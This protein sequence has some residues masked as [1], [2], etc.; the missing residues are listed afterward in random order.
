MD[1]WIRSQDKTRF[2]KCVGVEI[3]E[4]KQN[5]EF[6]LWGLKSNCTSYIMAKYKTVNRALEVIDEIQKILTP[7][8]CEL[9]QKIVNNEYSDYNK[10][11]NVYAIM[12]SCGTVIVSELSSVIYEMPEE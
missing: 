10:L 5:Q 2:I 11:T 7:Q 1:L 8:V 12:D 3:Q 4:N 9:A 6:Y